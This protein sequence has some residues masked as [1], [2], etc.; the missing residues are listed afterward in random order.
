[1]LDGKNLIIT[2]GNGCGKTS[3]IRSIYDFLK[4][5]IDRP[6]DH[7]INNLY[8]TL[9]SYKYHLNNGGR[10]DVNYNFYS[11]EIKNIELKIEQLKAI[12]IETK[13][14]EGETRSLLR[15]HKALREA[16]ITSPIAVPRLSALINEK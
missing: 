6:N 3:F 16:S 5:K 4:N 8:N 2:G 7:N 14:K 13:E 9:E 10:D 1:L 15:F 11:E 12:R